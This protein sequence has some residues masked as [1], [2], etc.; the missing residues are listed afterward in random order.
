L[1]AAE[2][3]FLDT[4]KTQTED[5]TNNLPKR[6][7]LTLEFQRYEITLPKT[8]CDISRQ[9]ETFKDAVKNQERRRIRKATQI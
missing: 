5:S 8:D 9:F 6:G 4:G 3:Q 2:S 1:A 7:A